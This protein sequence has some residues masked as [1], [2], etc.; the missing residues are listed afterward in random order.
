MA[1]AKLHVRDLLPTL[2]DLPG[3]LNDPNRFAGGPPRGLALIA[4]PSKTADIEAVMVP[5]VH[6]PG[7]VEIVVWG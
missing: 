1:S 5:Q 3:A 4:G 6:G 7:R 2:G